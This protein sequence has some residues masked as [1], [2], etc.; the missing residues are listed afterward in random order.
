MDLGILHKIRYQMRI[1]IKSTLPLTTMISCRM[2]LPVDRR[3]GV[4][5]PF[6]RL[7]TRS[8]CEREHAKEGIRYCA[9]AGYRVP[10]WWRLK[11]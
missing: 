9:L 11:S 5:Q 1:E 3:V 6:E 4:K 10:G 7:D 2:L 8:C